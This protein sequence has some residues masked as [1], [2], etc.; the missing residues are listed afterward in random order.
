MRVFDNNLGLNPAPCK[1][2]ISAEVDFDSTLS[3]EPSGPFPLHIFDGEK[4]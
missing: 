4:E 1:P 2:V 3:G